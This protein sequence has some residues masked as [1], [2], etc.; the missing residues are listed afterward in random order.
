MYIITVI[1]GN[2]V[3]CRTNTGLYSLSYKTSYRQFPWNFQA[4]GP[5]GI[6]QMALIV[7]GCLGSIAAEAPVEYQS[8][9]AISMSILTTSRLC[10]GR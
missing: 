6:C 5:P 2:Y 8:Y 9:K 3:C 7:D 1:G 10:E 4:A